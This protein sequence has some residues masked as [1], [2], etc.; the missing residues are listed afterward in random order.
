MQAW[1]ASFRLQGVVANGRK[2]YVFVGVAPGT[3]GISPG[4]GRWAAGGRWWV[5]IRK[6]LRQFGGATQLAGST[7]VLERC[8]SEPRVAAKDLVVRPPV[9]GREKAL[10]GLC[11]CG[12]GPGCKYAM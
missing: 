2:G 10:P 1:S 3:A 4:R 5:G 12:C 8:A 6:A 7:A 11:H 9:M